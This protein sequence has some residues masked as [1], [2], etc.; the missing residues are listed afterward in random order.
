MN[1]INLKTL[2]GITLCSTFAI[3]VAAQE[4]YDDGM[5][6]E[7]FIKEQKRLDGMTTEERTEELTKELEDAKKACMEGKPGS[8]DAYINARNSL[9]WQT[10]LPVVA[11]ENAAFPLLKS[12]GKKTQRT[13]DVE[14]KFEKDYPVFKECPPTKY[15]IPLGH[16]TSPG[17][18]ISLGYSNVKPPQAGYGTNITGG[19]KFVLLT[20]NPLTGFSIDGEIT[21]KDDKW[22][23]GFGYTDV[24]GSSEAQVA[25]GGEVLGIVYNDNSPSGS[26]GLNLGA[27]G[28]G[29]LTETDYNEVR[30]EFIR[31]TFPGIRDA[32][33]LFSNTEFGAGVRLSNTEHRAEV[34]TPTFSDIRSD[35]VQKINEKLLYL[36]GNSTFELISQ[37]NNSDIGLSV[38]PRVEAGYRTASLDSSQR[39]ICGLCGPADRD[40]T[41]NIEDKDSGVY[42]GANIEAK[43]EVK[44]SENTR[45]GVRASAWWRNKSAQIINPETG[46][47]LFVRNQPTQL[48]TD[49]I[50]GFTF[51]LTATYTWF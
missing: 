14:A 35:S 37:D 28:M 46:D 33:N 19:E 38:T 25:P 15:N 32:A 3:N 18:N 29:V 26:T 45:I 2:I 47:D 23:L 16:D 39:N 34:T 51:G 31:A 4:P 1:L 10:V 22:S 40:F 17:Y 8:R 36:V 5:T 11:S 13:L 48:G 24:D 21:V 42:V 44:V 6:T 50:S 9:Y 43:A 27:N 41:I 12:M 20:A 7:E 30:I 49:D